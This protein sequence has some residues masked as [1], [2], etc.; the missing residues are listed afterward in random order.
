MG[1]HWR[2]FAGVLAAASVAAFMTSGV[3]ASSQIVRLD[4]SM[5]GANEIPAADPDGDLVIV[6]S[7]A[8]RSGGPRTV[9][10]RSSV[11]GGVTWSDRTRLS[12]VRVN[13][14]FAAAVGV[15]DDEVRAYFGDQRSGVW[16]VRYR[17]TTDLGATWSKAVRISD[18]NS[19]TAYKTRRGF[20]EFYGDYG[21]IAVTNRGRTVA[22]W[23]E[24]SSYVGPG[25]VWFNRER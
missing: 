2:A 18:A 5:E 9:Y 15:G 10:A 16:N 23:G 11:D 24:G 8:A 4:A 12:R 3:A 14:A 7:G 21:E 25:G 20:D 17:T 6:Y 13:A 1:R 22:V 19:G